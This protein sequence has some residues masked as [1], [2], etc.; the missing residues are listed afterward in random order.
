[1]LKK[2]KKSFHTTNK[3]DFILVEWKKKLNNLMHFYSLLSRLISDGSIPPI[4]VG[5]FVFIL[6]RQPSEDFFFHIYCSYK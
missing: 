1:M 4:D 2:K 3:H 5:Q 6:R